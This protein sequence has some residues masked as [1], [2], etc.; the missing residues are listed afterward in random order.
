MGGLIE[1]S[2]LERLP[3]RGA[4]STKFSSGEALIAG[5]SAGMTGAPALAGR[6]A[7]RAGAGYVILFVPASAVPAVSAAGSAE[8]MCRALPESDGGHSPVGVEVVLAACERARA[9]WHSARGS[10]A[11]TAR[12]PSRAAWRERPPCRSSSTPTG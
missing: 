12:P 6:A 8:L 7:M 10:G 2:V 1:P 11:A 9:R 3:H 4:L 5:G